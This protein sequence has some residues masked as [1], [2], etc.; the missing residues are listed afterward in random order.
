MARLP[1]NLL[2]PPRLQGTAVDHGLSEIGQRQAALTAEALA[3]RPIEVVYSS[4]LLRA[5]ETA[6]T[7]ALAHNLEIQIEPALREV[8]VGSWENLQWDEIM[9]DHP[10]DY[11]RFIDEPGEHG[12]PGGETIQDVATRVIPVIHQIAERHGGAHVVAVA[13]NV[14]IK[15]ILAH[16]LELPSREGRKIPQKN[17]GINVITSKNGKLKPRMI[18]SL[19]HLGEQ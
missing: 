10:E 9:R 19:W 11:R 14:V 18:N 6:K 12:Y 1:H 13:H 5:K 17:C 3:Q 16:L 8:D 4:D 2:R 15:T 7:I